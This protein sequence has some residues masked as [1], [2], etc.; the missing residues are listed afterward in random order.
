[1]AHLNIGSVIFPDIDQVDLSGPHEVL[2]RLPDSTWRLYARSLN[3]VTDMKGL[4]FLPDATLEDAPQLDVL[5]IPGGFG[6][7][8]AMQDPVLMAWLR[9]QAERAQLVF[10]VCTGAILLG[11]TGLLRGRRATTH[12]ASHHLLPLLGAIPVDERVVED[13]PFV[14][15][16]GVTSGFDGALRVAARLRGEDVA[17]GIQ[18]YMQ[19]DPEPPFA[20][21]SPGKAPPRVVQMARDAFAPV[22]TQR[23][24]A[25][26]RLAAALPA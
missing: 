7:D 13:G 22:V 10:T 9:R 2:S 24:A 8:A 16:A 12:W 20:A 23:E 3:P 6:V 14:T 26:R 17:Q 25:L 18:L 1:M 4:R 19:Y 5:H 21:G 15:A 11:A